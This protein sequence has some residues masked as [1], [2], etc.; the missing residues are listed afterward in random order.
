VLQCV[1]VCCS[2]LRCVA[3]CCSAN[4]RCTRKPHR[5]T[6][7][8]SAV[9]AVTL[10][11]ING[12]GVATIHRLLKIIGLFCKRALEKRRYSAKKTCILRSLLIVATL[13][14]EGRLSDDYTEEHTNVRYQN[15]TH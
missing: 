5:L 1:A 11:G 13:Y 4:S 9:V 7:C 12:Y 10:V 15:F 8:C 2:V 14:L 6:V 3:V